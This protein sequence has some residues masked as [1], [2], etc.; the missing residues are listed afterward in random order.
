ML[1]RLA[2]VADGTGAAVAGI[3]RRAPRLR[4]GRGDRQGLARGAARGLAYERFTPDGPMALLPEGD[5]Y[6]L[7]WTLTPERAQALLALDDDDFLARARTRISAPRAG[8]FTRVADRRTFPLVLEFAREPCA[9][10]LRRC[11]ATRRRRCIRS[12]DR[13]STSA[14]A[15]RGSLAQ[16]VLDTPR[17]AHRRSTRCCAAMRAA[18]APIAWRASRS[19]T[20]RQRVRQRSC[21]SLRW[22]RGLALTL[23]DA[24]PAAKRAFTRAMLFGV[25]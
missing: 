10:A 19:R 12:R 1:A 11:S 21:R 22:P 16:V 5:H 7:V 8:G 15:T 9:R 18:G 24:V 3:A 6:G 17:D 25:P 20:A 13:D 4:A 2:A 23:L 14:C